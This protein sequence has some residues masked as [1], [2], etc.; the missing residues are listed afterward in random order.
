ME[1]NHFRFEGLIREVYRERMRK[2]MFGPTY[3]EICLKAA[4]P[5]GD[6]VLLKVVYGK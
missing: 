3:R 1:N 5:V 4:K 6:K 2:L